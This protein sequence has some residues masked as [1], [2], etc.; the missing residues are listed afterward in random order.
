MPGQVLEELRARALELW[1][2]G[3]LLDERVSVAARTLTPGEAIGDPEGDDFPILKGR[4][5][6]MEA[7]VL[8]ARGQAFSDRFGNFA[9]SLAEVA[10]MGL[11]NNYRRAVF[12]AALNASLRALGLCDRT[13]H[14][15]D[16]GPGQCAAQLQE[17][18][19]RR[20]GG[21]RVA[22]VGYQPKFV[23]ALAGTR[24]LRVLDLDPENIGRTMRG[25]LIEGPGSRDDVLAWAEVLL[26]TGSAL[27]NGSMG[28][29]LTD[30][31]LLVFGVSGAAAAR[32][33]GWERFCAVAD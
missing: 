13:V 10:S 33:M 6:L 15:R 9:G 2:A 31:P 17:Y 3:G 16:E 12:I 32:L 14:C 23:A 11:A 5:R 27:V 19:R 22:L 25:A 26:V 4:E 20:F 8:G 24:P 21:A 7:V 1:R 29:F 30:R 28:D 18:L